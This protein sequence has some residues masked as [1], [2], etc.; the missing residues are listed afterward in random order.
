MNLTEQGHFLM[1]CNENIM[2]VGI[3][4]METK[5]NHY[6]PPSRRMQF[7][8]RRKWPER[9]GAGDGVSW[10]RLKGNIVARNWISTE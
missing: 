9:Y 5:N 1:E 8:S 10:W 3:I 4:V 2:K 6:K 7:S